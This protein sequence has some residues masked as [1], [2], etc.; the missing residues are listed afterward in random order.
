MLAS[1]FDSDIAGEPLDY[2]IYLPPCYGLDGRVYPTLYIFAGNI[3]DETFWDSAG[4]D[5]AVEQAIQVGRMPPML[6]V[7]PDGGYMANNTSGGPYSYEGMILNELIPHIEQN[8]CAWD[9]ADGRAIGGLSRGGYWAL[10][11]AFRN[12]ELFAGV[13][14]HSASLLDYG[15][16]PDMAPL[17]TGVSN[18]LGDLQIYLDIGEDDWLRYGLEELHNALETAQVEH[19]W[20]LNAGEHVDAYWAEHAPE[21]VRWYGSLWPASRAGLPVCN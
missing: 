19:S 6:I 4:L 9:S 3:H 2:Q 14:G 1:S 18:E 5:E 13:G 11:I 20:T 7:M 12:P 16:G 8:Y 17:S 21:Y 10:E 15:A